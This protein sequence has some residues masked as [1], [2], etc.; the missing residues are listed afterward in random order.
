MTNRAY[1]KGDYTTALRLM[2]PL[3]DQGLAAAQN[4]LGWMYAHG[5]G[6]PQDEAEARKWF[7]KA[8]H[9]NVQNGSTAP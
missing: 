7:R 5:R 9:N 3:A 6:V 2:R 1:D 8:E 4:N